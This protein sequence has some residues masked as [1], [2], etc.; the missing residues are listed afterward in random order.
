MVCDIY[1]FVVRFLTMLSVGSATKAE[2][3]STDNYEHLEALKMALLRLPKIH[4]HVLDALV[5][6]LKTLVFRTIISSTHT[7]YRIRLIANTDVEETDEVYV[8]KLALSIG[9][10]KLLQF[11]HLPLAKVT[12]PFCVQRLKPAYQSR[13]VTQLRS[14]LILLSTMRTSYPPQLPRRK[15]TQNARCPSANGLLP[16]TCA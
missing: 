10:S 4:L 8:T 5:L 7:D 2:K 13:I 14:L 12:Q 16:S 11:T 6:H 15:A 3:G 9:R 1:S